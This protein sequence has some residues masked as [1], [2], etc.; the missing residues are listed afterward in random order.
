MI[1]FVCGGKLEPEPR[2][3]V[4]GYAG[5]V[6]AGPTIRLHRRC[7]TL[8]AQMVLTS[9]HTAQAE[10]APASRPAPARDIELT[11][12]EHRILPGLVAGKSNAQIARELGLARQTVKNGVSAILSKLEAASRTE[13]AV[14]A[15]RTGLVERDD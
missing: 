6:P 2:V 3:A 10:R 15:V 12:A 7:A 5:D 8:L 14:I 13:A 11:R 4:R 1:C 9:Y